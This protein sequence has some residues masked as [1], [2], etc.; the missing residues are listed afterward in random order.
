MADF[1]SYGNTKYQLRVGSK[2][3]HQKKY[4]RTFN[5]TLKERSTENNSEELQCI[6]LLIKTFITYVQNP[7]QTVSIKM[8]LKT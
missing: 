4:E 8:Q 6:F 5:V 2:L 7:F 3:V 1:I